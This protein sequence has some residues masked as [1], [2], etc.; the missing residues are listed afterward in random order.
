[1]DRKIIAA[2]V[3]AA[4]KKTRFARSQR[5]EQLVATHGFLAAGSSLKFALDVKRSTLA[6]PQLLA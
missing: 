6:M 1:V 5:S 4:Q 2:N 3:G